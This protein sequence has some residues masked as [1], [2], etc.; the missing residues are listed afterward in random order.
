MATFAAD[1]GRRVEAVVEPARDE[2]PGEG[3]CHDVGA[4][5]QH[6]AVVGAAPSAPGSTGRGRRPPGCPG[7]LLALMAM[8][9]PVPQTS[10][11]RCASPRATASATAMP[12]EGYAVG[13]SVAC[14]PWSRTSR[15]RGSAP[16]L[17]GEQ[18]LEGAT[19]A[20]GADRDDEDGLG[21]SIAS[22]VLE[23]VR[24]IATRSAM[25]SE[26]APGSMV[27]ML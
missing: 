25:A 6:L 26:R 1:G 2:R 14:T 3:G 4:H 5:A 8:P 17:V 13:S 16:Q 19:E 9:M 24:S 7:T 27:P 10:S 23:G 22:C 11:A 15:T 12:T 21:S 18:V 20:V